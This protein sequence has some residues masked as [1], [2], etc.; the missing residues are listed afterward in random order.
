MIIISDSPYPLIKYHVIKNNIE[1]RKLIFLQTKS[2]KDI[3][4]CLLEGVSYLDSGELV[5]NTFVIL[6][7][8]S[9]NLPLNIK[10]SKSNITYIVFSNKDLYNAHLNNEQLQSLHLSPLQYQHEITF[11]TPLFEIKAWEYFWSEY[12]VN[13]FQS[14]PVK[15]YNESKHLLFLFSERENKKF[16]IL[17][18]DLLYGKITNH[19]TNYLFNMFGPNSKKWLILLNEQE[20]FLLFIKGP[21][22][23]SEIQKSIEKYKPDILESYFFFKDSFLKG[24][25]RLKDSVLIL[26]YVIH[27]F[28][29]LTQNQIYNLFYLR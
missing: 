20:L 11:I 26:D 4:D 17:D 22:Y 28:D 6:Y 25:L 2:V 14:N 27:N 3:T 9:N 23:K 16:S 7:E 21:T 29:L 15:W 19:S 13:K 8:G 24:R 5:A 1:D 10:Q 12:C 18:I